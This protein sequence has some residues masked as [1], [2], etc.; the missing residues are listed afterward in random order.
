MSLSFYALVA[1]EC[2]VDTLERLRQSVSIDGVIGLAPSAVSDVNAVSGYV[3]IRDYARQHDL[4]CY[5]ANSYQLNHESD[6]Q[7]LAKLDIDVLAVLGW[8]RLVPNWL[9]EHCRVGVLG[10]HGSAD[11]IT[12][13]RGR[14]PQNWALLLNRPTF[15]VSLF[16]IDPG[17]DSGPILATRSFTYDVCDD[18]AVSYHKVSWLMA[19]MIAELMSDGNLERFVGHPQ[20]EADARYMPQR[21][22]EDGQIDWNRPAPDLCHFV[23]ALTRPYP[24]AWCSI[25]GGS[26]LVVWRAVPFSVPID[27]AHEQPGKV[28]ARHADD[29]LVI[30]C[31]GADSSTLLLVQDWEIDGEFARY[32]IGQGTQ[33]STV[34][35]T[36]QMAQIVDRH[37]QRYPECQITSDVLQAA[38]L[39]STS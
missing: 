13:G 35:F 22:P 17:V 6:K 18:I 19:D 2:G 14:S 23:R 26:R 32:Q 29:S 1:V 15:E 39:C 25:E 21:R 11:G 4:P 30:R 12:R 28:L 10:G 8:Q 27:V 16:R 9:I 7:M 36:K 20:S 33:L 3:D 38:S 34:D 5:L 37:T 24:G 31:G